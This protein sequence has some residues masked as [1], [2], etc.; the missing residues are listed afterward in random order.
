MSKFAKFV[1]EKFD[2]MAEKEFINAFL[3]LECR[4][5]S[6]FLLALGL[7]DDSRQ[8]ISPITR[9][10][11]GNSAHS[12]SAHLIHRIEMPTRLAHDCARCSDAH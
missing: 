8:R 1:D 11:P 5:F 10:I 7:S 3:L 6:Y 9:L 4:N 2:M 12:N